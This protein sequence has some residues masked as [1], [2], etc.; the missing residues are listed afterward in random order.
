MQRAWAHRDN[1][2]AVETCFEWD[3]IITLPESLSLV[4]AA[5][6]GGELSSAGD[7]L[8]ESAAATPGDCWRT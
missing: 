6:G 5:A 3:T 2:H 4:T 1:S 7:V 8:C